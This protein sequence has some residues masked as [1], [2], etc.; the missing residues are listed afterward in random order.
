MHIRYFSEITLGHLK[1]QQG[2]SERYQRRAIDVMLA[3]KLTLTYGKY[4][5]AMLHRQ[6]A[7]SEEWT[8]Y[9]QAERQAAMMN[10]MSIFHSSPS[11]FM[12]TQEKSTDESIAT[13]RE[14]KRLVEE[15]ADALLWYQQSKIDYYTFCQ[16]F[17]ELSWMDGKRTPLD[18]RR[19]K[20]YIMSMRE[21]VDFYK[22]L[23]FKSLNDCSNCSLNHNGGLSSIL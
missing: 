23:G 19:L 16:E 10:Q 21:V 3:A 18:G 5:L 7:M 22:S 17:Q 4:H 2:L 20:M 12:H 8:T 9:Q 13:Y 15:Y 11:D 1:P 6:L 14:F